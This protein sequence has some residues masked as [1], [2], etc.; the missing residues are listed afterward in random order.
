VVRVPER[1]VVEFA[2]GVAHG[3]ATTVIGPSERLR[4]LAREFT[5][6]GKV[7]GICDKVELRVGGAV[8][9]VDEDVVAAL[10]LVVDSVSAGH[11]VSV[12]VEV[13][14]PHRELSS[15]EAADVLNVSRPYVVKLAR[16]GVLP[17]RMV[18]NRHRFL[19]SDIHAYARSEAQRREQIL[20]S[21]VPAGGFTKDDF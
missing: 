8:F 14:S 19:A 11:N 20:A 15:Q 13:D 18:G 1:I 16:Q 12:V 6:L 9:E 10:R 4:G 5:R 21:L 2:T 3:R 7:A 17:H